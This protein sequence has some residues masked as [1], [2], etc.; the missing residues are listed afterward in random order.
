VYWLIPGDFNYAHR[1]GQEVLGRLH[2]LPE[3]IEGARPGFGAS[4]RFA[5]TTI[6]QA[7]IDTYGT[8]AALL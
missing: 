4:A 7:A 3:I 6:I 8:F 5:P 1:S 2:D